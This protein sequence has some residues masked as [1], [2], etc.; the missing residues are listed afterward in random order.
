MFYC[1]LMRKDK[2]QHFQKTLRITN[3]QIDRSIFGAFFKTSDVC[4]CKLLLFISK[5]ADDR[6]AI[7]QSYKSDFSI[8]KQVRIISGPTLV[9]DH[10]DGT[11]KISVNLG[12]LMNGQVNI[13]K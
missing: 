7:L 10:E 3:R 11:A 2:S 8:G 9:L 4:I 1:M 12:V 5:S 6:A 13:V